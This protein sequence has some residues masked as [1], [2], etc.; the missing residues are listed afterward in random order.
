MQYCGYMRMWMYAK[1]FLRIIDIHVYFVNQVLK[2]Y[3]CFDS[4]I[5]KHNTEKI[6]IAFQVTYYI[7][8]INFYK[9]FKIFSLLCLSRF[10]LFISLPFL[11]II[12]VHSTSVDSK[13]FLRYIF[14]QNLGFF[15]SR[16]AL[17]C[18]ISLLTLFLIC[19]RKYN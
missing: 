14:R 9:L 10:R 8:R 2:G 4:L 16:G 1:N 3:S 11:K 15:T 6:S 13:L 19:S 5:V 18:I 12:I 17:W 7:F